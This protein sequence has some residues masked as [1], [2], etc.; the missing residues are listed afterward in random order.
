MASG[1]LKESLAFGN[2]IVEG[3]KLQ[4]LTIQSH[5]A[6]YTTPY[7]HMNS[8]TVD[9]GDPI[10]GGG[11]HKFAYR[12]LILAMNKELLIHKDTEVEPP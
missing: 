7:S 4:S 5:E 12:L 6:V 9:P 1:V 8:F 11:G 10:I 3:K 2:I